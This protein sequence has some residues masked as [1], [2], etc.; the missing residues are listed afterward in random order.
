M[1][2]NFTKHLSHILMQ[3]YNRIT[4]FNIKKIEFSCLNAIVMA[5]LS[6]TLGIQMKCHNK[7]NNSKLFVN[8][9]LILYTLSSL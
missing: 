8:T 7:I 4:C 3:V 9:I 6:G 2:L 1:R 5:I